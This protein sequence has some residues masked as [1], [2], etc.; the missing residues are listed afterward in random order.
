MSLKSGD[1]S[2]FKYAIDAAEFGLN[3]K[4]LHSIMQKCIEMHNF[5]SKMYHFASKRYHFASKMYH[6]APKIHNSLSKM[7]NSASKMC[8]S[9][10]KCIILHQKCSIL[11]M[12]VY[13]PYSTH[14]GPDFVPAIIHT[15]FCSI[16]LVEKRFLHRFIANAIFN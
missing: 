6:F 14:I 1:N 3:S 2:T 10:S 5:A 4:M 16:L 15:A 7:Y 11:I 13:H 8:N 12:P 9:A